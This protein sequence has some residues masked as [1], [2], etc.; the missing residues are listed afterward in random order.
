[1]PPKAP[2]VSSVSINQN[3]V[4]TASVSPQQKEVLGASAKG[5][6]TECQLQIPTSE[7]QLQNQFKEM[8]KRDTACC[9]S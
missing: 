6:D 1:M 9:H 5:N 4:S 2:L 8:P 3:E 7:Q